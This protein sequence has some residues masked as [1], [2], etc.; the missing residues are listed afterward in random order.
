MYRPLDFKDWLARP[1]PRSKRRDFEKSIARRL[2]KGDK[3]TDGERSQLTQEIAGF[4][5]DNQHKLAS[6]DACFMLQVPGNLLNLSVGSFLVGLGIYLGF[7]FSKGLDPTAGKTASRATLIC[8]VVCVICCLAMFFVP[9]HLKTMDYAPIRR[10]I[11]TIDK[12]GTVQPST[13]DEEAHDGGNI[14]DP[15]ATVTWPVRVSVEPRLARESAVELGVR[16]GA[17][18]TVNHSYVSALQAAIK[19]QEESAR[20]IRSIL[21]AYNGAS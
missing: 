20:A 9:G 13:Q 14:T 2:K 18:K 10:W 4:L 7:V 12:R 6:L 21:E 16:E 3:L 1:C 19:A 11:K 5:N 17:T 8:Y 15:N